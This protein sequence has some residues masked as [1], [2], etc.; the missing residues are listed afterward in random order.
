VY[1]AVLPVIKLFF[2]IEYIDHV[3]NNTKKIGIQ[4]VELKIFKNL[5]VSVEC[6]RHLGVFTYKFK[7]RDTRT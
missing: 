4:S 6:R 5:L 1:P 2:F 7:T 3:Y